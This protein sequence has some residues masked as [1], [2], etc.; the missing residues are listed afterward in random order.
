MKNT[1]KKL[2]WDSDFFGL[3]MAHINCEGLTYG[4]YVEAEKFCSINGVRFLELLIDGHDVASTHQAEACGFNLA[5]IMSMGWQV[6]TI[7]QH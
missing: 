1:A 3:G 2:K 7:F 6:R 5:D 4:D